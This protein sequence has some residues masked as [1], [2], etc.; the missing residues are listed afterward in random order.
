MKKR[1]IFYLLLGL[2]SPTLISAQQLAK[3]VLQNFSPA[4][5]VKLNEI[6][7]KLNL[8]PD[9]QFALAKVLH[10]QDSA[11]ASGI[12]KGENYNQ[13]LQQ[14]V[15]YSNELNALLN[16]KEKYTLNLNQEIAFT[17]ASLRERYEG[18]LAME[19]ALA[20]VLKDKKVAL[21]KLNDS[22]TDPQELKKQAVAL[23]SKYDTL[24]EITIHKAKGRVFLKQKMALLDSIKP[25]TNEQKSK[26]SGLFLKNCAGTHKDYE[27][28]FFELLPKIL[29]DTVYYARIYKKEIQAK[30]NTETNS[31]IFRRALPVQ[32]FKYA[33]DIVNQYHKA[34]LV[35]DYA[36][37]VYNK[38]KVEDIKAIHLK[39]LPQIDSVLASNG[40]DGSNSLFSLALQARESLKLSEQQINMLREASGAMAKEQ[41]EFAM[42]Y[43]KAAFE[44]KPFYYEYLPKI[45]KDS[46]YLALL[47]PVYQ[48]Q[49]QQAA[50]KSWKQTLKYGLQKDVDSNMV[51]RLYTNFYLSRMVTRERYGYDTELQATQ[52]QLVEKAKPALLKKVDQ[53]V[54]NPSQATSIA[55]SLKW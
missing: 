49:A 14:K 31:F 5:L 50:E 26:L 38:Q 12:Q 53:L 9:R 22:V 32:A 33:G 21:D 44:P 43:P 27:I 13:L 10:K 47:R 35:L 20:M 2:L 6:N 37:P 28:L 18:D 40:F 15:I 19:R 34:L 17:A 3:S 51:K 11:M 48:P 23:I 55:G 24:T 36:V 41:K 39:Y 30:A 29:T 4:V 46:Q 45:L 8:S 16:D 52:V 1:M 7:V 54:R 42:A 25:L